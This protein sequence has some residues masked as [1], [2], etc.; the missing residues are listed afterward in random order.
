[1]HPKCGKQTPTMSICYSAV[2]TPVQIDNLF[3]VI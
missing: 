1:M 3:V 2:P